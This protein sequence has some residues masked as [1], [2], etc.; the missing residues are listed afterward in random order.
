MDLGPHAIF[1][2]ASYAAVAVVL[3]VLSGWLVLDGRRLQR[4][5]DHME[6]RGIRRR[7]SNTSDEKAK[8]P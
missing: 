5:L 3:T 1:I 7:S 4:L 8:A 6:A 2:W